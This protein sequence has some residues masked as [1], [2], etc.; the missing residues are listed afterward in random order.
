MAKVTI[1][2]LHKSY[3]GLHA[4][5]GLSF[6]IED[7]EFFSIL[8]PPGA[9]KSTTLK[10]IAGIEQPMAGSIAFDGQSVDSLPPNKR[11]VTMVFES[12]AL[13]PHMSAYQNIA[14]PLIERKR[15]L[16]LTDDQIKQRV[17]EI[18]DLLQITEH[19]GRRPAH[20]SGGQRQRVA[21]GRALVGEPCVQL[22]DEP[23]AHLDARLRHELRGELKRMQRKRRLTTVYA[24]P[25]YLEAIAMA[26]RVAVLFGG[27]IHQVGTPR[28]IL[29][30]PATASIA[31]FVGDPPMNVIETDLQVEEERL[32]LT[33]KSFRL[34]APARLR[35][36]LSN[37]RYGDKVLIGIRPADILISQAETAPP[38]FRTELYIIE[39]LHR[40][41]ILSLESCGDLLKVNTPI[42]FQA[43]I[44]EPIWLNF[45]EEKIYVF[46]Q[47][48][49]RV[50]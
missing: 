5:K 3:N 36:R 23:I 30:Q 22:L 6:E 21:L 39:R 28:E 48:T 41:S 32:Y 20:L 8:G 13:Y 14:Y 49:G 46:D 37:G 11:N 25:D 27:E 4:V 44:G 12:Y 31:G 38:A 42:S 35:P 24:T 18:A 47:K 7:G 43:D 15:Q 29:H 40:K 45:P 33:C 10:M 16:G 19:M 2:G 26:D 50:I 34:P 9:G 1:E 17:L